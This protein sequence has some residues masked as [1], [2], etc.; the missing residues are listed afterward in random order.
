MI[1]CLT[2]YSCIGKT[3]I[4]NYLNVN[5]NYS[6]ISVRS[7]SHFLAQKNGYSRTRKWLT[8]VSIGEY[9]SE[10]REYI[11]SSIDVNQDYVIDD[12]FDLQLWNKISRSF[13]SKLVALTLPYDERINRMI[14]RESL[15]CY[16]NAQSELNFLDAWKDRFGISNV[17]SAADIT[18]DTTDKQVCEIGEAIVSALKG[19]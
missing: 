18:I 4:S 7:V 2:G 12:L 5:Y 3:S 16:K 10:C 9:L 6:L 14:I 11:Y 13:D 8:A 15:D 1:M 17:I 19:V